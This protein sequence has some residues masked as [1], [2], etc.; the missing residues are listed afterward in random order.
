MPRFLI[1]QEIPVRHFNQIVAYK[2]RRASFADI[3]AAERC[4][5]KWTRELGSP[6]WISVKDA[7]GTVSGV[8]EVILDA[9]DRVWVEVSA[10]PGEPCLL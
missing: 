1:D 2:P 10:K 6:T 9:L 5:R 3:A 7:G 8:A 4:A